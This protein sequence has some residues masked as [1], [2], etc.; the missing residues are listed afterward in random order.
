MRLKSTGGKVVH[1]PLSFAFNMLELGGS[2]IQKYNTVFGTYEPNRSV[3]P[4]ML[5]PQL[6]ISDPENNI[7]SGD[8]ASFLTNVLWTL[9]IYKNGIGSKL[10]KGTD[11]TVDTTNALTFSKNVSTDE[12]VT[13]DFGADYLN[14]TR[15]EVSH[16]TW[17][18]SISTMAETEMNINITVKA[19]S[20]INFSP[21]KKFGQFPIEAV[22]KNGDTELDT[23][24]C[25]FHW[26]VFDD[27]TKKW[28][29]IQDEELWYVSGKD[30]STLVVDQ[31]Y[32]QHEIIRV[33]AFPVADKDKQDSEALLLRRR[34]GQWEDTPQ[35]AYA[36]FIMK[37]MQQ[38]LA[39]VKVTN[40]QGDI[41]D[42]TLY[43]DIE[44]LY[45]ES[46]SA[47]WKSIA[48]GTEAFIQRDQMTTNHEVGDICRE[49]TAY[50]PIELQDGSILVDETGLPLVAQFPISEREVE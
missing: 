42:P 26:Q 27:T 23:S 22:L 29:D 38:A 13:V 43:F 9:T 4:Y 8:Y 20:K 5:K 14:K 47:S 44:I 33:T 41:Q 21:F 12:I 48:Y 45:R 39:K 10:T 24:Q 17:S 16:F 40:R 18:R 3:A 28:I 37:D 1:A 7:P 2:Y 32:L 36:K 35:F 30:T 49:K 6:V 25:T 46:P 19:S 34:Y 31:D 15:G 50:L 11:Y